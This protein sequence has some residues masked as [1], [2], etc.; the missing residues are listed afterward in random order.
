LCYRLAKV[1]QSIGAFMKFTALVLALAALGIAGCNGSND[2]QN[3]GTAT[4]SSTAGTAGTSGATAS[5]GPAYSDIQA[6]FDKNCVSCHGADHP[7]AGLNLTSYDGVM[8]GGDDGAVV[9]QGDADGSL[10]VQVL[11]ADHKPHMPPK[12]Q[13]D[14]ATESALK[15]WIKNGAKNS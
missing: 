1:L 6:A 4:T 2:T 11:A 14:P 3:S 10:I 5:N 7:K 8:K 12:A 9:K 15:D 13:I